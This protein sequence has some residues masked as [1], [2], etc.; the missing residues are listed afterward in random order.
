[1]IPEM[2]RCGGGSS[3]INGHDN[4]VERSKIINIGAYL[5]KKR[6]MAGGETDM[7]TQVL[8]QVEAVELQPLIRR[9]SAL[10]EA[11]LL[12]LDAFVEEL[13]EEIEESEDIAYIE[14]HKDDPVVPF[15]M[16]DYE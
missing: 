4:R 14:A 6:D 11:S 3:D 2:A 9:I 13:I 5:Q 16:K 8:E 15:N 10:P 7:S 12:R 1:M